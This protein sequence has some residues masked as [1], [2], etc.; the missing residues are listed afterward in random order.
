MILG[1]GGQRPAVHRPSA[2]APA[3]HPACDHPDSVSLLREIQAAAIDD[4]TSV[5]T[6]LLKCQLLAARVSHEEF[7]TWVDFELNGY[8]PESELPEYRKQGYGRAVGSLAGAF[9]SGVKA[10]TLSM[11]QV[12]EKHRDTLFNID[13]RQ[14]ASA[15]EALAKDREG[16]LAMPWP[17]HFIAHYGRRNVF[18]EGMGLIGAHT[19]VPKGAIVAT[20]SAIRSRVLAVATE[21]ERAAPGAGDGLAGDD[22]LPRKVRAAMTNNIYGS[23][24]AVAGDIVQ[25]HKAS[26]SAGRNIKKATVVAGQGED[27]RRWFTRHPWWSAL[28]VALVAALGIYVATWGLQA[29]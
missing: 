6:L 7:A 14:P 18:V 4:K 17:G 28:V 26:V 15:L 3:I 8:P 9:G 21:I 13:L 16:Q 11:G 1:D 20:L 12:E 10:L 25:G 19:I 5:T 27:V 23:T 2:S 29:L 24:V 22:P